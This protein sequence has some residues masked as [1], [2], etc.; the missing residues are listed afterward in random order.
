MRPLGLPMGVAPRGGVRLAVG[1]FRPSAVGWSTPPPPS[2]LP[3]VE[4]RAAEGGVSVDGGVPTCRV[5]G[6][7]TPPGREPPPSPPP[8]EGRIA[9]T[10]CPR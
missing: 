4:P 7:D 3:G 9:S 1:V 8:P 5:G 6:R 2:E 10:G